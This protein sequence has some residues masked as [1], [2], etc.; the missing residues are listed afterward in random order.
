MRLIVSLANPL[1]ACRLQRN[2][3]TTFNLSTQPHSRYFEQAVQSS[4]A[5]VHVQHP[6]HIQT[7]SVD[8]C[9]LIE[10]KPFNHMQGGTLP[11]EV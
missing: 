1:S 7:R 8:T 9:A 2:A 3:S 10:V 4:L 11:P 6:P 5:T